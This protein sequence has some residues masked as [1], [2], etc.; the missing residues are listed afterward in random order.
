MIITGFPNKKF[1]YMKHCGYVIMNLKNWIQKH[2]KK[3]FSCLLVK[4]NQVK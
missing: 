3:E 2:M 1:H 4:I